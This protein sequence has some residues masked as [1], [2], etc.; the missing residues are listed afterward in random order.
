MTAALSRALIDVR[1]T[2]RAEL[3][4]WVRATLELDVP[5]HA[6]CPGHACPMDYLEHAFF[7]HA[8][9]ALVW[10]NRG[11][12]KTFYGAVATLLD[13]VFKPGIAVCILG[14]SFDQSQRMYEYL[15]DLLDRPGL[16]GLVAGKLTQRGA[17]LTNGSRVE[18]A[19]QSDTSIRGRRVQKLRCDE[20]DLFDR[21]RWRAAQFVTRSKWC[22]DTLVR[23]GVEAMSTMHRPY[24]L[25][26]ELTTAAG[27]RGAWRVLRWCAMDVIDRCEPWRACQGCSLWPACGGA[28]KAAAGFLPVADVLAQQARASREA[29]DSEML[30]KRPSTSNLVFPTF[31]PAIHVRP[32]D[33]EPKL[34]WVGGV[35]FGMRNPFVMLW[36]QLRPSAGGLCLEVIDEYVQSDRTLEQHVTA[37]GRRDWPWPAWVGVDPAGRARNDQTGASNVAV[38]GAAGYRVRHAGSRIDAGIELLRRRLTPADAALGPQ[39]L[40]HPRCTSLIR[41]IEAYHFDPDQPRNPTPVKDG[42]DHAIDALRYLAIN[43]ERSRGRIERRD[44]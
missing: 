28:A 21:E 32:L 41:S 38:L 30:C 29:F 16:R 12:G 2:T 40:I 25:M 36:A 7:D 23:G 20:V 37:L 18:L 35:D 33:A 17:R 44:Y 3:R 11:G 39:L 13:L 4:G 43:L 6:H 1:P 42:H 24:G 15:R 22:G 9:D 27:G 26:H 31:D 34:Q 5:D 10:A 19:A 8:P 14:G